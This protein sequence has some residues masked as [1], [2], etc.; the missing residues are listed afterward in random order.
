V[1]QAVDAQTPHTARSAKALADAGIV[2]AAGYHYNSTAAAIA[3]LHAAGRGFLLIA[4]FDSGSFHPPLTNPETGPDHARRAVAVAQA[5]RYPKGCAIYFTQDTDLQPNQYERALGYWDGAD[6]IVRAAG[7]R[8]GAYGEATFI[9]LLVDRGKADLAWQAGADSWAGFTNSK[10]A[11]FRQLPKQATFGGV[12][13]DLNNIIKDDCGAW[14][15]GQSGAQQ[16]PTHPE[17]DTVTPEDIEA[18]AQRVAVLLTNRPGEVAPFSQNL[19]HIVDQNDATLRAITGQPDVAQLVVDELGPNAPG[20]N[21]YS[22]AAVID[23][24]KAIEAKLP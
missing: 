1:S 4:E 16:T 20:T 3:N 14:M 7:Y 17:E 22:I 24:L 23:R 9:D 2:F 18:V 12:Q 13:C 21:A 15:P 11:C 10:H 8:V 5:L 19:A 6:D